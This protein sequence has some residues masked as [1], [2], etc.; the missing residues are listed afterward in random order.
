MRLDDPPADRE[1]EADAARAAAGAEL[2]VGLEHA[3]AVLGRDAGA[4]VGDA[5]LHPAA[6]AGMLGHDARARRDLDHAARA[7]ELHGVS[8]QVREHLLDAQRIAA[9]LARVRVERDA[10]AQAAL[11]E[12]RLEHRGH[13]LDRGRERRAA[14]L[15]HLARH[16]R[17]REAA[18]MLARNALEPL[19]APVALFE[20]LA[21]L[22]VERTHVRAEQQAV[23]AADHGERRAQLVADRV[24]QLGAL[25]GV[26][27]QALAQRF[28]LAVHARELLA[29]LEQLGLEPLRASVGGRLG[30][31]FRG[32]RGQRQRHRAPP[33]AWYM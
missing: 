11:R 2:H 28:E 26:A 12:Q 17:T 13:R 31:G 9:R 10:Q 8:D 6:H 32:Q 20:E 24:D 33:G 18:S 22:L 15:E 5:D 25:G 7:R 4:V 1:P 14:Q 27:A 3:L 16:G 29:G 30:I 23:V 21:L 19:A